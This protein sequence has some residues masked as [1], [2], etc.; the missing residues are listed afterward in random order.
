MLWK[1]R[2]QND[3]VYEKYE[4]FATVF[5]RNTKRNAKMLIADDRFY[6]KYEIIAKSLIAERLF[7][8]KICK[9]CETFDCRT[10][11]F[12]RNKSFFRN[13]GLPN[14]SFYEKYGNVAKLLIAEHR[15]YEKY[16]KLAKL[17]I[18]ERPYLREIRKVC[19]TYDCRTTVFMRSTKSLQNF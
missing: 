13:S 16:K 18:A 1:C 8:R 12:I 5:T 6:K 17:L 10:S 7:L 11:I 2:L 15:F 3:R 9:C 19:K 4:K 14:D